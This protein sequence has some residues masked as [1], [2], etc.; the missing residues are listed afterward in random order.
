M[1]TNK[2]KRA[3]SRD[4]WLVMTAFFMYIVYVHLTKFLCSSGGAKA[5]YMKVRGVQSQII[6]TV[7]HLIK[8]DHN[9]HM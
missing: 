2:L 8:S 6:I 9:N 4:H 5:E 3:L 7:S 1:R